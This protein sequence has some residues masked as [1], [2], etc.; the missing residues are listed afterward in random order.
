MLQQRQRILDDAIHIHFGKFGAAGARKVQQVIHN[1]GCAESLFG[2]FFQQLRLFLVA[3]ELLGEHLRVAGDHG[4]RRIN[5][6]RNA[7]GQQSDG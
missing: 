2:D 3:M 6:M 5:F 4:Q 7:G 1:L